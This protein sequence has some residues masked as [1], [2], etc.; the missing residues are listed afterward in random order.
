[1]KY[2]VRL[3][4]AFLNRF[5]GILIFSIFLGLA[6][7]FLIEKVIPNITNLKTIRIGIT[8]RF[9]PEELPD[10]ITKKISHGLSSIAAD[11]SAINDIAS[12]K[13]D[14]NGKTW[15]FTLNKNIYWQDGKKLVAS[16]INYEF[17][18]VDINVNSENSITYKLKDPFI[19]FP[20][21]VSKP[22]FRKGLLG[23]GDWKVKKLKLNGRYVQQLDLS[24][25]NGDNLS[26][27]FYP[28]EDATKTAFKL[29]KVDKIENIFDESPF[30]KWKNVKSETIINKD[31][32][33]T[34]FFNTQDKFL[35]DKSVRQALTYA[36]DKNLLGPRAISPISSNSWAYNPQVKEYAFDPGRAKDILKD[37]PKDVLSNANISLTTSPVLVD[38]A[39]MISKQWQNIGIKSSVEV[40]PIVPSDFQAYL[41]ILD[42]PDDPDQY[43]LWHSTQVSTNISKYSNPRIDKLLEDGRVQSN[44][45]ERRKIYL[46]FQRFLLE[47]LPAAFLYNP[48]YYNISR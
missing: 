23:V 48:T 6:A 14:D 15:V 3:T 27:I 17:S 30:N 31:Q 13:T 2:F 4:L 39:D 26:Y 46:D 16:D 32:V 22:I 43:P 42:L 9:I 34:L 12:W 5:K 10:E 7:F 40:S 18:D 37:I 20:S 21:V 35:A 19:P 33:V 38:K 45:D 8:G 44:L 1:M 36:I 11:G 29:G 25:N 28:S 41:T 47:D 24:N